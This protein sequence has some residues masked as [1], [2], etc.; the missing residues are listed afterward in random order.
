[1][2]DMN[3]NVGVN[4]EMNGGESGAGGDEE[5]QQDNEAEDDEAVDELL[6]SILGE[7]GSTSITSMRSV[8]IAAAVAA[9]TSNP[10]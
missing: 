9:R 2:P 5:V 10:T 4:Q 3:N 1:M 7:D 8:A 6:D